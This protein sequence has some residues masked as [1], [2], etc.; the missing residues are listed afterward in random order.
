M[1]ETKSIVLPASSPASESLPRVLSVQLKDGVAYLPQMDAGS[2]T[3]AVETNPKLKGQLR[4]SRRTL[5]MRV[6]PMWSGVLVTY[7]TDKGD[8]VSGVLPM[9]HLKCVRLDPEWKP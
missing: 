8:K 4:L 2:S 9:G 3:I 5:E 7:E 1:A 6:A